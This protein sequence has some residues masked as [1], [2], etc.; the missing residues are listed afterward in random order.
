MSRLLYATGCRNLNYAPESGSRRT[1][2]RIKKQVNLDAMKASIAERHSAGTRHQEQY[3][4]RVPGETHWDIL[5]TTKWLASQA[6]LGVQEAT[7]TEYIPYPG[8]EIYDGLR[9]EG[10]L[11]DF[12]DEYFDALATKGNFL[13]NKSWSDH[14]SHRALSRYIIFG[15]L[16]FLGL[17][18]GI[19]PWRLY[20]AI[21]NVVRGRPEQ[22]RLEATLRT[23]FGGKL[24]R[25]SLRRSAVSRTSHLE[26][27]HVVRDCRVT[28]GPREEMAPRPRQPKLLSIY[29]TRGIVSFPPILTWSG[30]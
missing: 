11:S 15:N 3:D 12:S 25:I 16:M 17:S 27:V 4:R 14:V 30:R 7:I 9:A 1:L 10:K 26:H 2:K 22:S 13:A 18:T 28:P 19:R 6:I 29:R 21:M 23:I 8:T 24:F 5:L 20:R